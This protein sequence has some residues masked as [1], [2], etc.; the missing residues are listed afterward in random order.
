LKPKRASDSNPM[1]TDEEET[2]LE[3]QKKWVILQIND[4]K[5][6]IDMSKI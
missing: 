5:L 4:W 1:K 3:T 2:R 6:S